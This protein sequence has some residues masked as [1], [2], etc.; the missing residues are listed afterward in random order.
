MSGYG[1]LFLFIGEIFSQG[2]SKGKNCYCITYNG[3]K[4]ENIH[5]YSSFA[6]N[7]NLQKQIDFYVNEGSQSIQG[8]ANRLPLWQHICL[9][10]LTDKY[11]T[12]KKYI[13]CKFCLCQ[14]FYPCCGYWLNTSV[15]INLTAKLPYKA[16]K[17]RHQ[18]SLLFC[19]AYSFLTP[20]CGAL[21]TF[22]GIPPVLA[23]ILHF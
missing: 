2:V 21:T 17:R 20:S 6:G 11:K 1:R 15:S 8:R 22:L 9:L 13:L 18:P 14:S 5:V 19:V 10:I 12:V 3:Y 4:R 16:Q 7:I 23:R